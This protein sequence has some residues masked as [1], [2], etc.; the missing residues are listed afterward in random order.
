[1]GNDGLEVGLKEF[2]RMKGLDRDII[3]YNNLKHIRKKLGD[4]KLHKKLQYWWLSVLTAAFLTWL[5]IKNFM[6]F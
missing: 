1:M 6:G 2:K 5:G 4:Y 3:M